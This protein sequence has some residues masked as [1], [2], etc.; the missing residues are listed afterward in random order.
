M[1]PHPVTTE[2]VHKELLHWGLD[3][4]VATLPD[5]VEADVIAVDASM[6]SEAHHR[7]Y[8]YIDLTDNAPFAFQFLSYPPTELQHMRYLDTFQLAR[9]VVL[10]GE[11]VV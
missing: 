8:V 6:L 9:A 10:F 3:E 4:H 1:L 11:M 5:C 7:C 2:M